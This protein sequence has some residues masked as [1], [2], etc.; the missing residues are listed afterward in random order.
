ML[1]PGEHDGASVGSWSTSTALP[2]TP[3]LAEDAHQHLRL[4]LVHRK[5][6]TICKV[7]LGRALGEGGAQGGRPALLGMA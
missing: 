2:F 7:P 4:R 6:S 1:R 5:A 3:E